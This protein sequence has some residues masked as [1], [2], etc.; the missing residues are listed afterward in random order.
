MR[1]VAFH[2]SSYTAMPVLAL[3]G[4]VQLVHRTPSF[5][6]C[7]LQGVPRYKEHAHAEAEL[8]REILRCNLDQREM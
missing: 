6:V 7:T 8:L 5:D 1:L 2:P 3:I 4:A